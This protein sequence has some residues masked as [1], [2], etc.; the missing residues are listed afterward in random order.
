LQR[1]RKP[2]DENRSDV[3]SAVGTGAYREIVG[4]LGDEK[5]ASSRFREGVDRQAAD[6]AKSE[7]AIQH[8]QDRLGAA[9]V[10][11]H[12]HLSARIRVL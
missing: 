8:V 5:Y 9:A 4:H 11:E 2:T 6:M 7:P 3:A 12:F 1:S 10:D